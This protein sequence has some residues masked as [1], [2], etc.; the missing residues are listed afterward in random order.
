M[1]V[2]F[3]IAEKHIGDG[4]VFFIRRN[5]ILKIFGLFYLHIAVNETHTVKFTFPYQDAAFFV[6]VN[7]FVNNSS[8]GATYG[9][10]KMSKEGWG[11]VIAHEVLHLVIVAGGRVPTE[12]N[13]THHTEIFRNYVNPTKSL[14]IDAFGVSE[15]DAIKLALG[16]LGDLWNFSNF[17]SL[18]DSEYGVTL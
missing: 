2:P 7:A 1:R 17:A 16:G 10:T 5:H 4:A 12:T 8:N 3:S 14:L 15:T 6:S 11:A 18:A 9:A 13:L